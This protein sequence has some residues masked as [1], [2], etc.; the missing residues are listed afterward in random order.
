[1]KQW[2]HN[3]DGCPQTFSCLTSKTSKCQ[4]IRRTNQRLYTLS[5]IPELIEKKYEIS[6]NIIKLR[7]KENKD[8]SVIV[9]QI[10]AKVM[11]IV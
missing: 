2:K 8:I 1:M 4:L 7:G 11:Q 6:I 9:S 5:T 10:F 3:Y